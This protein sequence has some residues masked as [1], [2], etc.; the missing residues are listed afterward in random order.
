MN[1]AQMLLAAPEFWVLVMTCVIMIVDLFLREQRRGFIH[2]LAMMTV[3][4]GIIITTRGG[5][6]MGGGESELAFSDHFVRDRMSDVL[7]V[8]AFVTMGLIFTYSKFYL[9][10]FKLFR[11]DFYTLS[12]FSLLGVMLLISANSM[13]MLYL[14][15][16]MI[17]L[18]VYA[19]V[20]F[21]R[22]SGRGSESA[23]KYF[24]LGSLAS[25]ILLYGMSMI[26]GATGSL[27]IPDIAV[28]FSVEIVKQ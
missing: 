24:V 12:Q 6:L 25:G 16:E 18:S 9:R 7:K 4:F 15:L 8:F 13:L 26:Y 10:N 5:F 17:S 21:D 1:G 20:A 14:G 2:L 11:A 3:V 23:M 19:L 27:L 28:D 22:S